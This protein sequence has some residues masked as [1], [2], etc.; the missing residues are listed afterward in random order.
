MTTEPGAGTE[1]GAKTPVISVITVVYNNRDGFIRTAESVRQQVGADWEWVVI[2]GGSKDGTRDAIVSFQDDIA[3]WVSERDGGIYDAMNKGIAQ[4]KGRFLVFMNSGDRLAGPDTLRIVSEAIAKADPDIGMLLGA[5]RFELSETYSYVQ[6]A[7]P[8]DPYIYHSV[9]TSHQAMYFSTALHRR[10]LFDQKIRIAAD[11]DAI[12][13]MFKM[14]SKAAYVDDVL[15]LVWR[16]LESNSIRFPLA[17]IRDMAATQRRVFG[18]SYP[19]IFA[20][21]VKRALP[22][23]AFRLMSNPWTASVTGK[24][25]ALLRPS[26]AGQPH[27]GQAP[28]PKGQ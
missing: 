14:N 3:Y 2:D 20:S 4:A 17:N 28:G 18:L 21:A 9:P 11:Y 24:L 16:G 1:N 6:P 7:R 8:M 23:V 22:V 19:R 15:A 25:I 26:R 12:C 27:G 5:A 13:R 10:A